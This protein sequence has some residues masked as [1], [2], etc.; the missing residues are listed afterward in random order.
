MK[1]Y[2]ATLE[3]EG[4]VFNV[5]VTDDLRYIERVEK[6]GAVCYFKFKR[7]HGAHAEREEHVPTRGRQEFFSMWEKISNKVLY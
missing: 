4:Y 3:H 1:D 2:R 7:G 5:H 6:D